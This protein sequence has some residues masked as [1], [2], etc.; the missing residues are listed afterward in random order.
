M[1]LP[2]F[3]GQPSLEAFLTAEEVR[4]YVSPGG[5]ATSRYRHT[6][7]ATAAEGLAARGE[8][9]TFDCNTSMA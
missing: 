1:Y 2:I 7:A 3:L 5:A 4:L 9:S 8:N 6:A